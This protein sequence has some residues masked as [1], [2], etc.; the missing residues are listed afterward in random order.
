MAGHILYWRVSRVANKGFSVAGHILYWRVCRVA[1][2]GFSVAGHILYW[3]VCRVANK[4]HIKRT[5]LTWSLI[6]AG[7][8]AIYRQES[9]QGKHEHGTQHKAVQ[10]WPNSTQTLDSFPPEK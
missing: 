2:K 6:R 10:T 3:R 8:L 4:A 5:C 1:N 7:S 9:I